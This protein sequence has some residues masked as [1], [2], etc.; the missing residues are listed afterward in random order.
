VSGWDRVLSIAEIVRFMRGRLTPCGGI[1]RLR[2]GSIP[3]PAASVMSS[4]AV[5]G[6]SH[7]RTSARLRERVHVASDDAA[8]LARTLASG[9]REAVVLATCNRTELYITGSDAGAAEEQAQLAFAELA[10]AAGAG[11][12]L[13]TDEQAARHLFRVASGLE[14]IVIG[15][16]HV[17]AQVRQAHA[18]ARASGATGPLLDRLFEA[19]AAA[20]KRVR[21]N[22]SVQAGPTSIPGAAVAAAA[23]IVG[24]LSERRVVVVGAGRTA[25]TAARHA[26]A[27]GS[28]DIVVANRTAERA[29]QLADEVDGRAIAIDE[30]DSVLGGADVVI[31][32]TSSPGFVLT[33]DHAAAAGAQRAGRPLA[34]FDIALPRDVDPVFRELPATRLFDLDDLGLIVAANGAA[35][36]VDLQLADAIVDEEVRRYEEWR[37]ARSA[38]P[39]IAALRNDA[40]HTRRAVLARHAAGLA[41]LD[42]AQ[43]TLVE[44]ITSQLV[45]KLLH[46][47]MLELRRHALECDAPLA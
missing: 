30:L 13:Y 40:E 36:R 7:E 33:L 11:D 19:A 12:Y 9:M 5:V 46:T 32:A 10:G 22:T 3:Q 44:T 4:V 31:S 28:R 41:Q 35:R 45:A 8:A 14:S 17:V 21:S 1:V 23:R 18:A 43:R 2:D 39:A 15:D 42:P 20:S 26:A 29:H 27:R 34:M 37:R 38:A 24:P 6:I 25:R 16:T 47:P